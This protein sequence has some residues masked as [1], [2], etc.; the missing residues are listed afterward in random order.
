MF[1]WWEWNVEG[2]IR[3]SVIGNQLFRTHYPRRQSCRCGRGDA[4]GPEGAGKPAG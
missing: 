3:L 2:L 1:C 4:T